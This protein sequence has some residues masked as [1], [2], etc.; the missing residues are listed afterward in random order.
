MI[1]MWNWVVLALLWGA[2]GD[3]RSGMLGLG[4]GP[5]EAED[6]GR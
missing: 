2:G 6:A 3:D 4:V 1:D 5:V